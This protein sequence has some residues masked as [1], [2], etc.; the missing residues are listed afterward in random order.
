MRRRHE[1]LG[2]RAVSLY[3]C[4]HV[5]NF[6]AAVLLRGERNLRTL[7]L[8]VSTGKPPNCFVYAAN[9]TARKGGI[10]EGMPLT[11]AMARFTA[12]RS[13]KLGA[14]GS[15]SGERAGGIRP[16]RL[17]PS[18]PAVGAE[19]NA[20]RRAGTDTSVGPNCQLGPARVPVATGVPVASGQ[21]L[22]VLSRNP[23]AER[24]TQRELIE[25]ALTISPRVE[26]V[27]PGVVLVELAGIADPHGAAEDFFHKVEKLHLP[28]HVAVSCNR[29]TAL[30]AARARP[31]ITHIFPGWQAGFLHALP[32]DVLPL[33]SEELRTFKRW[34]LD[35]V[36][37]LARLSE[38]SLVARF[39]TRGVEFAKMARGKLDSV[40][41]PYEAPP[42]FEES[43]DFE[44]EVT[45]LEPLSF[46]LSDLLDRLC[47][48]MQGSG[49]A[50]EQIRL[51]L[52]LTGGSRFERNVSLPSPLADRRVLL[53]L[54]RLDLS[55]HPP[56]EAIEGVKVAARTTPRRR[57]QFSLFEPMQPS[58]EKLAVTLARLVN[59][60]GP[61]RVGAPL[62]VDTH[63]PGAFALV[64]FAPPAEKKKRRRGGSG[65]RLI[66]AEPKELSTAVP[67]ASA[68]NPTATSSAGTLAGPI[69]VPRRGRQDAFGETSQETGTACRVSIPRG[70][71]MPFR[72]NG[73]IPQQ[74]NLETAPPGHGDTAQLRGVSPVFRCFRPSLDAEVILDG[75]RPVTVHA[76]EIQGEVQT[77]AGPWKVRGEW[78]TTGPGHYE[79]WDVDVRGKLYR[80]C[81][82]RPGERWYVM[83]VYD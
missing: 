72:H 69:Q 61:D 1:R 22:K 54:V 83:G 37:E 46:L 32:L 24:Q 48:K 41:Q 2:D 9:E 3:A 67:A 6:P 60:V 45:E 74:I 64:G 18:V 21:P 76:G 35:T 56:G 81:C 5:P 19:S 43:L 50:A 16:Y 66:S 27:S 26:D 29:F 15:L 13:K 11:E 14:A 77:R 51:V 49:L 53:T 75:K 63:R 55:V 4:L 8:T 80:I 71:G 40:L 78:W 57:V 25:T 36:G 20:Q 39:G 17:R 34:G 52:K 33:D 79:E 23:E 68:T 10:R 44:W 31:G 30:C 58:P 62:V 42:A 47:L 70:N 28:A 65:V 59:L 38:D 7:P 73:A 12:A 82:E